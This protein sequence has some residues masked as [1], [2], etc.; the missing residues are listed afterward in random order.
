MTWARPLLWIS[1]LVIILFAGVI[2]LA[3]ACPVFQ[4]F[5]LPWSGYIGTFFG[6][7]VGLG[8]L[9]WAA[10]LNAEQNRELLR[11]QRKAKNEA[12]ARALIV[13]LHDICGH[14]SGDLSMVLETQNKVRETG[15]IPNATEWAKNF[16]HRETFPEFE[17]FSIGVVEIVQLPG[18]LG[19]DVL[20]LQKNYRSFQNSFYFSG[21][22]IRPDKVEQ[23]EELVLAFRRFL[24]KAIV[25]RKDLSVFVGEPDTRG[26]QHPDQ[27]KAASA[28]NHDEELK[29]LEEHWASRV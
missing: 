1:V 19:A 21:T 18:K 27:I 15:V 28:S 6:A 23:I 2:L 8:A 12:L 25:V 24:F 22:L 29:K 4:A 3:A 10:L 7:V 20:G 13:E 16:Y 26:L 5:I 14:M 9:G 17:T 11:E